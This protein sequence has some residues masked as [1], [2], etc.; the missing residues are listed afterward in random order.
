[1][2]KNQN[3]F[4]V[5]LTVNGDKM[6][7]EFSSDKRLIDFLREDMK[8]TGTKE[9]CGLGE[10]GVCTVLL[11]GK[12]VNSCL[13]LLS[14]VHGS[15]VETIESL[16]RPDIVLHPLQRS[17]I[18]SGAIQCGFCTPGMI[19]SLK[20]LVDTTPEPDEEQIKKQIA[21]NLC[22]CTGYKKIIDAVNSVIIER[23]KHGTT[24]F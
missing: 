11:N 8:L 1:M 19:L 16:S 15:S 7:R 4:I 12:P 24:T 6:E 22:R 5:Q 17:F 2:Q 13:V 3:N 20:A 23:R 18:E 21:G 14:Q 10:C 9:G